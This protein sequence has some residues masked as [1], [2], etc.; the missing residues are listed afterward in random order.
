M[1]EICEICTNKYPA[2]MMI[3]KIYSD[4]NQCYDCLFSM[5]FNEKSIINGSM[6]I[7]LKDYIDISI[8]HHAIINE[9]PCNRLSDIGGCY[10]C[11]KLL[12][13][14]FDDHSNTQHNISNDTQNDKYNDT[15]IQNDKK[16]NN[17]ETTYQ[18]HIITIDNNNTF[19]NNTFNTED[20]ILDL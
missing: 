1:T 17:I 13:I 16:I 14:P 20:L 19:N 11:M 10:I 5:N 3:D 15:Y 7:K 18:S 12:D 8:K 9:I 2:E 4:F 6:G